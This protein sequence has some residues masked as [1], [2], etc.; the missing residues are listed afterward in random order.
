MEEES[1]A[2]LIVT[3]LT[4]EMEGSEASS[5]LH[6][7]IG[8][9]LAEAPHRPTEPLPGGLV[10]GS[11][12]VQLV[13]VVEAGALLDQHLHDLQVTPGR[14]SLEGRVSSLK[15]RVITKSSS[16]TK[17]R[18]LQSPGRWRHIL[19]PA[20]PPQWPAGPR[21]QTRAEP[22]RPPGTGN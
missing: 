15:R 10:Q 19:C 7:D 1:P 18:Y 4:A 2:G 9:G 16:S 17:S 21:W 11:V 12:A 13:L 3:A 5:V 22:S 14:G 6:V 8:L 20:R